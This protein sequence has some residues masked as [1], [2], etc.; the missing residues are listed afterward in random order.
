MSLLTGLD[1]ILRDP[2]PW[3]KDRRVGL[4]CNQASVTS[5]YQPAHLALQ[6]ILGKNLRR[7]FAP[8]HGLY[9]TKQANMIPS[10]DHIDP[11]TGLPVISLYG[12]RLQPELTHLEDLDLLLV[13]LQDVGCRVYTYIWTLYL[14]LEV[15]EKAGVEVAILDRPNPLG[16][17]IEGPLLSPACFSFVG[18]SELPMRHGLTLGEAALLFKKR[19]RLDL[20]LRVVTVEG[21]H[22]RQLF[23]E[24]GLPWIMPSPNMPSF[25]TALVYPGQVILE[26]T[27]LSEG[28][29]TTRPF[30]LFGAPWLS[31]AEL[32]RDLQQLSLPGVCLRPVA[33]EPT[34]DKWQ[35]QTCYG[36]QLHVTDPHRFRP[37]RT[38]LL[39]LRL[40]KEREEKFGFRPPPYE[41]EE[42]LLPIEIIVGKPELVEFISGKQ[43]LEALDFY[44]KEGLTYYQNEVASLGLYEGR[45]FL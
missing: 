25:E 3:L 7:L 21:W 28:R 43:D 33:F 6:T 38:T 16:G 41:F 40:I 34:F 39:I 29:G 5:N 44:L 2:P 15:A 1:R 32:Y 24:T 30:E 13:D 45:L 11:L 14:L 22:L 42:K 35:G 8:Q 31:L 26:G 27:N 23:P 37:V 19:R 9:T 18:L 12:P 17:Y 36:F 20:P 4:L 10:E